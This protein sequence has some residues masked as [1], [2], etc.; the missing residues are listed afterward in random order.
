MTEPSVPSPG[1]KGGGPRNVLPADER[2]LLDAFDLLGPQGTVGWNFDDAVR[3]LVEPNEAPGRPAGWGGLPVDLWH[4]GRS[5]KASERVLGDVVKILA[6][7]LTEYTDRAVEEGH[8]VVASEVAELRQ[9]ALDAIRF[10][11]ARVEQLESRLDP[12]GLRASQLDLPN[13]TGSEWSAAAA[14]WSAARSDLPTVVGELGD[15]ALLSSL[16]DSGVQIEGVDPRGAVVWAADAKFGAATGQIDIV[17]ADVGDHL[18]SLPDA[19]RGCVVLAGSVDRSDLARKIDIV[20]QA[21]R[22]VARGGSLALLVTD[23]SAWDDALGPVVR[24][25]LPGRPLHP[26][27]WLA[28]LEDR[29]LHDPKWMRPATGCVHAIV[30]E[31]GR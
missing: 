30:A 24:D 7:D 16:V 15:S 27:T 12:V 17:F 9:S 23:Q 3:R 18:R 29:G 22:V 19:S 6:Q 14:G 31:V 1:E 13:F 11:A 10:L 2:E 5:T 20:D 21:K 8:Q 26:E 4:R 28:V 25:L